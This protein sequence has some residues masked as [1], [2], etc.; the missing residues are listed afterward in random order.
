MKLFIWYHQYRSGS[1]YFCETVEQARE[2]NKKQSHG[3]CDD[4]KK[5]PW[6]YQIQHKDPDEVIE[7]P[8]TIS[9]IEFGF[10]R[11]MAR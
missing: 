5:N 4:E 10:V 3:N 6:G 7:T 2:F 1:M 9:V 11:D 8:T